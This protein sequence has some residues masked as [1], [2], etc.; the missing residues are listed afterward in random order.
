MPEKNN[1]ITVY[2]DGSS[3][4]N[5]GPGGWGALIAYSDRV[6]ELGGSEKNTTNNRMELTAA[7]KALV[8]A[9]NMDVRVIIHTDSAYVINGITKWVHK[10]HLNDWMTATKNPVLNKDLWEKL[11]ALASTRDVIWEHVAG[12]AGVPGNERVDHIATSFAME[13]TFPLYNG[14]RKKYEADVCPL[15]GV[16]SK[17]STRPARKHSFT[18]AYSY[19]SLIDGKLK[20]HTTWA[21]CEKRVK[22]KQGVKYRKATSVVDEQAIMKMWG[23]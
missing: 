8:L 13:G 10:W 18:K 21:D 19:L 17:T 5:P 7:I 23:L 12:H 6:V 2:T 22:G 1:M 14:P 11:F 16:V 3:L 15:H 9:G 20:R 4:G